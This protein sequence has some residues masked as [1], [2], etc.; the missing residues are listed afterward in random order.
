M[1]IV[2]VKKE[3]HQAIHSTGNLKQ[4]GALLDIRAENSNAN[5]K[6]Y[7]FYNLRT[8][9]STRKEFDE[10]KVDFAVG[11]TRKIHWHHFDEK[12]T[13]ECVGDGPRL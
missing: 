4:H 1:D 7:L 3:H 11:A 9:H 8:V 12:R 2:C 10:S 5:I 6:E 13:P